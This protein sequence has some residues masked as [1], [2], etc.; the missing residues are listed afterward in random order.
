M[1]KTFGNAIG[2][3]GLSGLLG[4]LGL[5]RLLGLLGLLGLLRAREREQQNG[6]FAS[7]SA[8]WSAHER[9]YKLNLFCKPE[10]ILE[11]MRTALPLLPLIPPT[12]S[13]PGPFRS[14]LPHE[15][16]TVRIQKGL[17]R[18]GARLRK[19]STGL[20]HAPRSSAPRIE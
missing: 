2:L 19:I 3:L 8:S 11:R 20:A 13:F 16:A 15:I 12:V 7:R 18:I 9:E 17:R 5:L 4:L 10:L 6:Q 1:R 14:L